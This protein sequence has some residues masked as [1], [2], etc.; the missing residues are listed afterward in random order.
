MVEAPLTLTLT[1][2]AMLSVMTTLSDMR[3]RWALITGGSSGI[4]AAFAHE[5]AIQGANLVLVARD[6][7]R[8]DQTAARLRQLH[9][10]AVRTVPLN[11]DGRDAVA[12]LSGTLTESGMDVELL[13]NSAGISSRGLVSDTDPSVLRQLV[14][15]NVGALT[16]LTGTV[17]ADMVRRGHGSIINVA[18]TGA[19]TPA[20]VVAAYAASKA[21]VLS[22]TQALWAETRDSGVRV[23]AVSPGPTQTPMNSA[24]GPGKRRP[25]QVARTALAMLEKEGPAV[26]DGRRNTMMARVI[27]MLPPHVMA[28]LALRLAE[29]K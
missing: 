8:L 26:V 15:L 9:R 2:R 17:V 20:P 10:V 21:Y 18:S 19:Y 13:V 29:G 23:V 7:S 24:P 3:G 4:G 12:T 11:L 6:A 27:R 25:E 14:D 1:S 22:F 16:E 5:L 28:P